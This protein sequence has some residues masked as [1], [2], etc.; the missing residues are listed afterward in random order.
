MEI[1]EATRDDLDPIMKIIDAARQLMRDSGNLTQW[2]NGYPSEELILEDIKN[3]HAFLCIENGEAV[4]YF[5]FMQGDDPDPCYRV[6]EG[7]AWLSDGPYGVI[8]RLASSGKVKGIAQQAFNFAFTRI[9]NIKVDTHQ[10][11]VPMQN[12]LRKNAFSFCGIIY[13][14]DGS[15]RAAFQKLL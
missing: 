4:G 11:N 7:G 5:C 15:P 6:I 2:T 10:D 14:G 9:G 13:V 12:Y 1:R 8:H 3:N